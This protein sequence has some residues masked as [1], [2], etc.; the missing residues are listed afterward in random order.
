M[1]K[2][3]FVKNSANQDGCLLKIAS[4]DNM[5]ANHNGFTSNSVDSFE[6]SDADFNA[7]IGGEK[8]P[9]SH[10]GTN[11]N[12]QDLDPNSVEWPD[13]A[14]L[15]RYLSNYVLI[16][17]KWLEHNT[18]HPLYNKLQTYLSWVESLD[19]SSLTPMTGTFEKYA[20]SQEKEPVHLLELI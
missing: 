20:I 10:D 6:I 3:F 2:V 5:F 11:I 7:I 13:E 18:E 1:A 12:W 16:A 14:I 19:T 15:K 4:N 8:T 17:K 9:K